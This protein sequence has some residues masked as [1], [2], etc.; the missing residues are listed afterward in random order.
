[1]RFF[2]T[3]VRFFQQNA[4]LKKNLLKFLKIFLKV[5]KKCYSLMIKK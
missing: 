1:M 4:G 5:R 3:H 2:L